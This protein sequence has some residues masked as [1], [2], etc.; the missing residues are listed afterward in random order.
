MPLMTSM[1]LKIHLFTFDLSAKH[2][3]ERL[4]K[5]GS[6][7]RRIRINGRHSL[8]LTR[9]VI[10]FRHLEFLDLNF[11]WTP[12]YFEVDPKYPDYPA[13]LNQLSELDSLSSFLITPPQPLNSKTLSTTGFR[14]LKR[15]AITGDIQSFSS[16]CRMASRIEYL[17]VEMSSS[18]YHAKWQSFFEVI[19]MSCPLLKDIRIH[20]RYDIEEI[21]MSVLKHLE[22]MRTFS[23]TGLCIKS[24][25]PIR[26]ELSDADVGEIATFWPGLVHLKV[27]ADCVY[28]TPNIP[29]IKGVR[30]ILQACD[31]LR[32]LRMSCDNKALK[33]S[34]FRNIPKAFTLDNTYPPFTTFV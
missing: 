7:L 1:M 29:S 3:L 28:M 24:N 32:Y 23:L 14:N 34:T 31:E 21:S 30:A 20:G 2:Y 33:L 17:V 19:Q 13:L 11:H 10:D 16:I 12:D 5:I 27:F 8:A 26:L 22:P 18:E 4:Y 9:T 6:Q 15:L 25:V